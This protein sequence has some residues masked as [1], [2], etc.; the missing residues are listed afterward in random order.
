M[1]TTQHAYEAVIR[2][3]TVIDELMDALVSGL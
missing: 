1:L 2:I 3:T